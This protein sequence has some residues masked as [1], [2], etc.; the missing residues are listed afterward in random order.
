MSK[1][2]GVAV[3]ATQEIDRKKL[4]TKMWHV[5]ISPENKPCTLM[6]NQADL[7][8]PARYLRKST[9]GN[10]GSVVEIYPVAFGEVL[11]ATVDYVIGYCP[12][13]GD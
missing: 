2:Q 1:C 10:N 6:P 8:E 3:M 13:L 12:P 7:V 11:H 5:D 4:S 9:C